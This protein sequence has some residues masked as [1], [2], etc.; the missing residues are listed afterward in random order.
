MYRMALVATIGCDS[1]EDSGHCMGG[2]AG[3]VPPGAARSLC[4][5][6]CIQWRYQNHSGGQRGWCGGRW[7]EGGPVTEATIANRVGPGVPGPARPVAAGVVA[8]E[9]V[10]GSAGGACGEGEVW[11]FHG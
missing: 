10:V 5:R 11:S 6:F 8:V 3:G 9:V 1:E 4:R 2:C 7:E